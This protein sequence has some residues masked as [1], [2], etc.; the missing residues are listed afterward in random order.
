MFSA[1]LF[2]ND[3]L[4]KCKKKKQ[5]GKFIIYS[6]QARHIDNLIRKEAVIG[7]RESSVLR[8]ESNLL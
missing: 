6:R 5:K 1:I 7:R 4:L 8:I 3:Y 2:F